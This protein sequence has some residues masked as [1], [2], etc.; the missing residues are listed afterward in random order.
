MPWEAR[1]AHGIILKKREREDRGG[2]KEKNKEG[3]WEVGREP[4]EGGSWRSAQ[5]G[6]ATSA[7]G[8]ARG[9]LLFGGEGGDL[10]QGLKNA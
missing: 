4:R 9:E 1:R 3:K 10:S 7:C 6:N 5:G 2:A 8:T